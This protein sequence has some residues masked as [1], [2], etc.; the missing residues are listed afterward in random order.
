MAPTS[1]PPGT[2]SAFAPE[3]PPTPVRRLAP[4]PKLDGPEPRGVDTPRDRVVEQVRPLVIDCYE[5]T[6]S[7]GKGRVRVVLRLDREGKVKRADVTVTGTLA[8]KLQDCASDR[9]RS[10]RLRV[11]AE[12]PRFMSFPVVLPNR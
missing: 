7:R 10:Q 4:K 8:R 12:T 1:Q 11:D 2:S 5:A 9:I 6:G 3:P